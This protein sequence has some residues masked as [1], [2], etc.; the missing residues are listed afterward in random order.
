MRLQQ[1]GERERARLTAKYNA[2]RHLRR[3]K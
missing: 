3:L 1:Q 2:V